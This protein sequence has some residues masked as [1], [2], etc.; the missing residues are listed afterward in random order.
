[1]A[2]AF[3]QH[4]VLPGASSTYEQLETVLEAQELFLVSDEG[5]RAPVS[6]ELKRVLADIVDALH[7]GE[8]VTVT[9]RA[10]TLTTQ[11]AADM[12]GVSRPT[13]VKLLSD[14]QI[15][16]EQP[17]RHRRVQLRDLLKFQSLMR[18]RRKESIEQLAEAAAER[19][20]D[21]PDDFVSTR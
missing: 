3:A 10:T 1:M 14:G 12:L 7:R 6:G 2:P 19:L 13:L 15:P 21:P 11:Q 20:D 16:Y 17:G 5:V 4:T 8:A 9:P 18:D